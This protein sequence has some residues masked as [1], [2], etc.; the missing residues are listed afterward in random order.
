ML[1]P[2]DLACICLKSLSSLKAKPETGVERL[3]FMQRESYEGSGNQLRKVLGE[4][5]TEL[6][7]PGHLVEGDRCEAS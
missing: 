7:V 2:W 6:S 4:F 5:Y 1:F 3:G